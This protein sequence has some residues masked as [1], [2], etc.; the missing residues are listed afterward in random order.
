MKR[1]A[2]HLAI[3]S[4]LEA[5]AATHPRAPI[6]R[7]AG[8]SLIFTMHHVCPAEMKPFDPNAGLSI[9]PEF[10]E[11]VIEECRACGFSPVRLHELPQRLAAHPKGRFVAFTLDDGC[12]DN[13]D[14]A[15]PVFRRHNV[16]YTLFVTKGFA[17]RSATMWWETAEAAIR[18][19]DHWNLDGQPMCCETIA[20]KNEAYARTVAFHALAGNDNAAVTAIEL[21][22]E[23]VGIDGL[24]IVRT[25]T[26][27]ERELKALIT[28]DDLADFGVHT[29]N[30][31]ALAK[32]PEDI[33]RREI[34]ESVSWIEELSGRR[35][36]AIAYP[37]GHEWACG[38]REA[39]AA[40]EA[41]LSIGV[42]TRPGKLARVLSQSM[43]L[44]R[45]SL[46]GLY[47]ERRFVRAF[48]SGRLL[49]ET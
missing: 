29:L 44:P 43:L 45:V 3:R 17:R 15:A 42:T 31:P 1:V 7:K 2:R 28:S 10:L 38:E 20:Q 14:H 23:E 6:R 4:A 46:N 5:I 9:T 40:R 13:R 39:N 26:L 22:A 34:T 41:G 12:R 48:L 36:A 18:G 27:S 8:H 33:M 32:L 49:K 35:P 19:A 24:A 30:H 21:A 11:T 37:Y 16:P 25:Q 47:Q